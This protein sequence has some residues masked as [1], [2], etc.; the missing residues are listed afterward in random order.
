MRLVLALR[1]VVIPHFELAPL[2]NARQLYVPITWLPPDLIVIIVLF[3]YLVHKLALKL[4]NV[5]E[6]EGTVGTD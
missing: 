2:E 5:L 4:P 3:I 1:L 6:R